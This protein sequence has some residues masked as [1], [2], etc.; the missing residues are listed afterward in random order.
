MTEAQSGGDC[1]GHTL[2][3]CESP[4]KVLGDSPPLTISSPGGCLCYPSP[5]LARYPNWAQEG[6]VELKIY[7]PVFPY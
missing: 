6:L 1:P 2:L 4:P 3:V 7:S 5:Q